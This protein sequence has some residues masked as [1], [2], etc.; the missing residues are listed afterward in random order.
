MLSVWPQLQIGYAHASFTVLNT[1]VTASTIPLTISVPLLFHPAE[2]FFLG[3]AP[4]LRTQ[5]TSSASAMGMSMDQSKQT[6]IGLT[7]VIG[8]YFG[9]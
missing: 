3:L 7:A 4:I 5:L 8:G 1:D 2:H 6:D 9:G